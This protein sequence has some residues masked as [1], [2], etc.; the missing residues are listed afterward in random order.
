MVL[1][2][3]SCVDEE[4]GSSSLSSPSSSP[5]FCFLYSTGENHMTSGT[6]RWDDLTSILGCLCFHHMLARLNSYLNADAHFLFLDLIK[7]SFFV[8]FCCFKR[9]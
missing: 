4:A 7:I 1:R 2:S 5:S 6:R 3:C 8:V 9:F